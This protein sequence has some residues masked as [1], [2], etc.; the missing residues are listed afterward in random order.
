M[1][2]ANWDNKKS[3][4][5]LCVASKHVKQQMS[6]EKIVPNHSHASTTAS[7]ADMNNTVLTQIYTKAYQQV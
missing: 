2:Q 4:L 1:K 5:M 3:T 6:Y 7:Y